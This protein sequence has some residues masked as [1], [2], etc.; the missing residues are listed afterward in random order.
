M[1]GVWNSVVRRRFV[2]PFVGVEE[3]S[4]AERFA[5]VFEQD[6]FFQTVGRVV[7]AAF[8]CVLELSEDAQTFARLTAV[9][10][11]SAAIR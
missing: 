7:Y 6:L 5:A 3:L 10:A 8:S 4:L 1:S 11:A 2:S 9:M